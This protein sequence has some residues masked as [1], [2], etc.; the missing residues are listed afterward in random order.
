MPRL[1]G[2]RLATLV[3]KAAKSCSG[4]PNLSSDKRLH[5]KLD[6]GALLMRIGAREGAELRGR[7]GQRAAPSQRVIDPHQRAIDQ[8]LVGLVQRGDAGD[9]VDQPQ[10]QMV[11]Q[12]LAD[13]GLV[14]H[15]R[16]A[17]LGEMRRRTYA[18]QAAAIAASRSRR[19]PESPRRGSARTGSRRSG[20]SARRRALAIELDLLGE[21]SGLDPQIGAAHHRLEKA[22]RRRPAPSHLLVDVKIAATFV[23]AGIEIVGFRNAGLRRRFPERIGDVPAQPRIFD[24]PF[25]ALAVML[26]VS[27]ESDRAASETAASHRPSPS[28]RGRAGASDRNRP[29]ARAYRSWR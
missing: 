4:S 10:L 29:T 6:I 25:A 9:L 7:H 16:N 8:R 26:A 27:R 18:R 12:I 23:V 2:R 14:Q 24:A 20:E 3:V 19:P 1:V 15:G 28:R 13:A 11:L 5:M 17:A 22:A 21:A